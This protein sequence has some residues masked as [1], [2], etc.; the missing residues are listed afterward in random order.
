M[1]FC[2]EYN[3]IEL[4]P[5]KSQILRMGK[6]GSKK[7]LMTMYDIPIKNEAKYLGVWIN[8]EKLEHARVTRTLYANTNNIFRQNTNIRNCSFQS[9]RNILNAYGNIYALESFKEITSQM[10]AAHRY[11]T[12]FVFTKEWKL[13]ADLSNENGWLDIRSRS[14]YACMKFFHSQKDIVF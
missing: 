1:I 5:N 7:I 13:K 14:L 6:K 4:N 2:S 12:K 11:M 9:K 8:N 10:R 3:D